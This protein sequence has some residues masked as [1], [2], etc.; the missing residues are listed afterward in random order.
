V[1]LAR[2]PSISR[3]L[4]ADLVLPE[5]HPRS[6]D[7][8]CRVFGYVVHHP[9]GPIVVDTGVGRGSD[10]IGR[11]YQPR[12]HDLPARLAEVGVD[13]RE[14][15]AV[16]CSHLHFDHC[17][18]NAA[19]AAPVHVQAAE[20]EAAAEPGYTV[21]DW[22][23]LPDGR[24]RVVD[25][26]AEVAEGVRLLAT[27]G[28]TPGHQSVVVTGGEE[29]VVLVGQCTYTAAEFGAGTV[30]LED[31]H[32]PS[33]HGTA[34]ESVRRLGALRPTRAAFAHDEAEFTA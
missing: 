12:V 8:T 20:R 1:A 24:W 5:W 13:E 14:V 17:G 22:A 29:V 28:H 3:L 25:G 30:A 23:A 7:G 2:L 31:A 11:L 27:P 34:V 26:D 16:V 6:A 10:L 9:D 21:P 18:Q 33:W 32:D 15:A 4:L 19:L